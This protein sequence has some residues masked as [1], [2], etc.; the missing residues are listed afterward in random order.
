MIPENNTSISLKKYNRNRVY[1]YL[2]DRHGKTLKDISNDLNLSMPTVIQLIKELKEENLVVTGER[3][4]SSCGRKAKL[5]FCNSSAYYSVGVDI[6]KNHVTFL[7]IDLQG[8]IIKSIRIKFPFENSELYFSQFYTHLNGFLQ[9]CNVEKDRILGVGIAIPGILSK[10]HR[11]M[12]Y[13]GVID[14]VGGDLNRFCEGLPYRCLFSNDANAGGYAELWRKDK[15]DKAVY[16]SLSNSVGGAILIDDSIYDGDNQKS[17]EFGHMTIADGGR[18]CYCGRRGCVDAYCSATVLS[19]SG[20][21][22]EDFFRK[23]KAGEPEQQKVWEEYKHYLILTINN[24]RICFD[25][26]VILGGYVGNCL[27]DYLEEIREGLKPYCLFDTSTDYVKIC[28][29]KREAAAVGVALQ[30][31]KEFINQI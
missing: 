12:K 8:C 5:L 19:Q 20:G 9:S 25:C 23:L 11:S 29:Y 21:T 4:Q 24:L 31:V 30:H 15:A 2:Y 1:K 18:I 27:E 6:T 13:G 7:I 28:H 14:F 22:L 10:D 16:L 26:Q 3:K 17:A